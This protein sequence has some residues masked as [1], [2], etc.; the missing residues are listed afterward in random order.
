MSLFSRFFRW[1]PSPFKRLREHLHIETEWQEFKHH[2]RPH[3]YKIYLA[4][5]VLSYPLYAPYFRSAKDW[6]AYHISLRINNL[7]HPERAPFQITDNL[8]PLDYSV[9]KIY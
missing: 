4:V 8:Y 7:L 6:L 5:A 1:L 2:I 9:S 3:Q